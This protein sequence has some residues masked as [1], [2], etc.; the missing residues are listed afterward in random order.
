[1]R[2]GDVAV[3]QT[4]FERRAGQESPLQTCRGAIDAAGQHLKHGTFHV[5]GATTRGM[6]VQHLAV[7]DVHG[8]GRDCRAY[9]HDA[10]PLAG[11]APLDD[12][13]AHVDGPHNALDHDASSA[14]GCEIILEHAVV[15]LEVGQRRGRREVLREGQG[16]TALRSALREGAVAHLQRLRHEEKSCTAFASCTNK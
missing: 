11:A 8:G 12:A 13:A 9:G 10:A 3:H 4:C 7:P 1:M 14:D 6:H 2:V 5:E 15:D 16:S